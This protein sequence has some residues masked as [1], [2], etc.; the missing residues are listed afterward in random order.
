M[1]DQ[2]ELNRRMQRM[3][4]LQ[5]GDMYCDDF[6]REKLP[7]STHRNRILNSKNSKILSSV[8]F[9]YKTGEI[10]EIRHSGKGAIL[11]YAHNR[12]AIKVNL[13][14]GLGDSKYF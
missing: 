4:N 14:R 6:S 1:V 13:L 11:Y 9:N 10:K 8:E 3:F 7:R 12:E 5:E 2:F